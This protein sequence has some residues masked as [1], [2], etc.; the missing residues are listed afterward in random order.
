MENSREPNPNS[1]ESQNSGDN[2]PL[3][4][5]EMEEND[6]ENEEYDDDNS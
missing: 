5:D 6:K 4:I 1:K 3:E 2:P